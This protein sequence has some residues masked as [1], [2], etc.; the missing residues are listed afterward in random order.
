[1][2]LLSLPP[3]LLHKIF[4]NVLSP[5][6]SPLDVV[7]LTLIHPS[8]TPLAHEFFFLS[9]PL[10]SDTQLR[11][12]LASTAFQRH[13]HLTR[14]IVFDASQG[15][16]IGTGGIG[17]EETISGK[18]VQ[19]L[20]QVVE[21]AHERTVGKEAK[22]VELDIKDCRD[23]RPSILEGKS[24][25]NLKTLTL[26]TGFAFE[27]SIARD[28]TSDS[29]DDLTTLQPYPI[30]C[31]FHLTSL[32]V[33]NNH[34]ESLPTSFLSSLLS[35]TCQSTLRTLN[36][37]SL[38]SVETFSPLLDSDSPLFSTVSILYLPPF[39]TLAQILFST[40]LLDQTSQL[41]YLEL[42][43]L[44]NPRSNFLLLP[45]IQTL[46][47]DVTKYEEIGFQNNPD[48]TLLDSILIVLQTFY[49]GPPGSFEAESA[50]CRLEKVRMCRV[51]RAGQG[52]EGTIGGTAKVAEML[53][54][55]GELVVDLIGQFGLDVEYGAY[56]E[57][58]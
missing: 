6:R 11:S 20:L 32:T 53:G 9:L 13:A 52:G 19:D 16:G 15:R 22:L 5:L 7:P 46:S 27:K 1:M 57:R 45:L 42:P 47:K 4:T 38:Y 17:S 12:L 55:E 33:T 26:G 23:M 2:S 49:Q 51:A 37:S 21:E 28:E 24:L 31:Q 8:L 36:L 10:S 54:R 43:S 35:Q 58:T 44:S 18:W 41:N 48:Q 14:K 34:W 30:K 56:A 3:E 40:L 29:E 39:E 50:G 25:K